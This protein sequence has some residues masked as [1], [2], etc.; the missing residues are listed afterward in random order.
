MMCHSR[1]SYYRTEERESTAET[2][3]KSED[4]R[5]RARRHDGLVA[6][7]KTRFA[8]LFEKAGEDERRVPEPT[9][10]VREAGERREE[11]AADEEEEPMPAD[12]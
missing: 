2:E 6:R 8:S 11:I 4:E 7:T 3:R 1:G 9:V 10:T 12:D 5:E